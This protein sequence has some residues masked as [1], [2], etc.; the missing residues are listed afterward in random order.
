MK[1]VFISTLL[2]WMVLM[3]PMSA[4]AQNEATTTSNENFPKLS[5]DNIKDIISLMTLEEKASLII[6]T[7]SKT[8]DG[9]GYTKLYVPGA[10]GTTLPIPRLG[11]PAVVLADG[12]AG[13]R[14]LD[15]P[16]TKFPI[17]TSLSSSWNP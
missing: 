5:A 7:R 1:K 2:A 4:I 17:G 13:V 8:F 9:V 11:I 14:I 10:A 12:P 6:G 15:R 16:C 3:S